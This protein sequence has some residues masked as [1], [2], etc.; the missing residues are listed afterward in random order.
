MLV[1]VT[2][3]GFV[4]GPLGTLLVVGILLLC[5]LLM[6]GM[7]HGGR[8]RGDDGRRIRLSCAERRVRGLAAVG[9]DDFG[10]G[11]WVLVIINS[12]I[13]IAFAPPAFSI[14]G[15]GVTGGQRGPSRAL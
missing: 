7:Q 8:S 10:G 11:L 14:P 2:G 4:G 13:F 6:L 9:G 3:A 1:V 12:V 15:S 5:P